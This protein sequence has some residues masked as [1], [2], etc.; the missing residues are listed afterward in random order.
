MMD[1]FVE[2]HSHSEI[3]SLFYYSIYPICEFWG[4]WIY[5]RWWVKS[6]IPSS[7]IH[8]VS[9]PCYLSLPFFGHLFTLS[10][11]HFHHVCS[12]PEE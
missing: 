12:F 11:K 4:R 9:L 10:S 5:P 1:T 3:K 6:L 7:S 2:S 8:P